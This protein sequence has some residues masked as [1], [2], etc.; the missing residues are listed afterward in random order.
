MPSHDQQEPLLALLL[1]MA[2]SLYSNCFV[3]FLLFCPPFRTVLCQYYDHCW[4]VSHSYNGG[5]AVSSPRP[6][7]RPDAQ[8]GKARPHA[9]QRQLHLTF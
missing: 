3:S 9:V 1:Q 5:A 4:D 6:K 7:R 8:M 2:S